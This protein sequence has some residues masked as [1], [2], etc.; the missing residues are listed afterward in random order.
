MT[1]K[2]IEE[3]AILALKNFIQGSDVISQYITDNDKEPFWD[4]HLYLYGKDDKAKD[5]FIG[6]VP[7]QLKGKEVDK[8]KQKKFKFN[9]ST[10]DLRAYLREPT[11]Y[12]VCQEKNKGKETLL[13]YRCLL[14]ETIKNILK[15]KN[16]QKTV[17]VAMKSFPST[18][19][20]FEDILMVFCGDAKK[21]I[22]FAN[23]KTLTFEEMKKRNIKNFSFIAPSLS[24]S[25]ID[26]FGYLSS[27]NSY[28][29]A[30]INKEFNIEIPISEEL[31]SVSFQNVVKKDI[32]VGDK[33]FFT[34]YKNEIKDGK[35]TIYIGDVLRFTFLLDNSNSD[36]KA[37][38]KSTSK[39]LDDSIKEA[40]FILALNKEECLTIGDLPLHLNINEQEL[41]K[42]LTIRID[43]WKKLKSVLSLLHVTK[44]LD[45]CTIKKEQ[46]RLID[47]VIH[48]FCT[49]ETVNI[50]HKDNTIVLA[51]IGNLNI[52]L[53]E[54]VDE[55]GNSRFGDFFDGQI[56]IKCKFKDNNMYLLSPFSY[57]QKDNL[58][59]KCDNIRFDSLINSYEQL[60]D[61]NPYVFEMANM[62][63][64]YM[65]EAYDKLSD[66]DSLRK[67]EL[68]VNSEKLSCWLMDKNNSEQIDDMYFL[69]YCQVL[70]REDKLLEEHY[71]RLRQILLNESSNSS[72]KVGASLLIGDRKEFETCFS[73]CSK[74]EVAN[75]KR[76]PI[77]HFYND[78]E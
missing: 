12:I 13:F 67:E 28:M 49:G 74:E 14:P 31:V 21:Q 56:S 29:Y 34:E 26:F 45:L 55:E 35:W 11:V 77:W 41:I 51:E 15:G 68:I 23:K 72:I 71:V 7:V 44:P 19:V 61:K 27:H 69:N 37:T 75:L 18:L 6:K 78:F 38:F 47:I 52:L 63:L 65:L 58:W 9:I 22:G 66:S 1:S 48:A 33:V 40:E 24:M 25:P 2:D 5:S 32:A 73:K 62:D 20:D 60:I 30:Q 16:K 64:I 50:G 43:G 57:L 8:F 10:N 53:L 17:S 70:K 46:E 76:F 3:G 42:D 59:Q 4:G 39:T 36:V 54:T